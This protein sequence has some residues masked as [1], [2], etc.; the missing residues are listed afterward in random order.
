MISHNKC[1][2]LMFPNST[3]KRATRQTDIYTLSLHLSSLF[4]LSVQ[5]KHLDDP[6]YK[7]M[8]CH[9]D[10]VTPL[11]IQI[12][13]GVLAPCSIAPVIFEHHFKMHLYSWNDK[14]RFLV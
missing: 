5:V 13:G 6:F 3:K 8:S 2:I 9:L 12:H 7:Q 10:T 11:A 14:W 1:N 4:H